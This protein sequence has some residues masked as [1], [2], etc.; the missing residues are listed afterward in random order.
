MPNM[1]PSRFGGPNGTAGTENFKDLFLKV[2]AGEV[3][4]AFEQQTIMLDKHKIR[5][6]SS[7]KSA[8]FPVIGTSTAAYHTPGTQLT[9]D[10]I[11]SNEKVVTI[12]GLLVASTSIANIDEAMSHFDVRGTYS[13]EM[14]ITLGNAFDKN[15]LQEGILGARAAA[16]ITGGNGGTSIINPK[17]KLASGDLGTAG[18]ATTLV[19]KG[20]ALTDSIIAAATRLDI[21]NAPKDRYCVLRPAEFYALFN[22]TDI[23]NS[24]YGNGGNLATG[25]LPQIGGIKILSS[26]NL[27]YDDLTAASFHGVNAKTV[28]GLVFCPE[29]LGTVKLMDLSIQSEF[30]I[31]YQTTLM[32][33][34]YAMGHSYLRPEALVEIKTA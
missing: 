18:T 20:K 16:L 33:A 6:I 5:T 34:R 4:T 22:N 29:A 2:F 28:T 1:T 25:Q 23:L 21:N 15:V 27:A 10:A 24:L 30:L 7:G 26:N 32:V 13:S 31:E 19:E 9:G 12:D 11:K 8:Q 14:G 3:L 17:T